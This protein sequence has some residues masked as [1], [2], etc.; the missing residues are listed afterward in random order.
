M[1]IKTVIPS[2]E[3]ILTRINQELDELEGLIEQ[4]S[5]EDI[6]QKTDEIQKLFEN[7]SCAE[8]GWLKSLERYENLTRDTQKMKRE[9]EALDW[10]AQE[11]LDS[12]EIQELDEMKREID[13]YDAKIEY[14]EHVKGT[15]EKL[16]TELASVE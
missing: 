6:W 5:L 2:N 9:M 4:G 13:A 15:I 12:I 3:N 8:E 14:M 7:P 16:L 1:S 10:L 11:Q